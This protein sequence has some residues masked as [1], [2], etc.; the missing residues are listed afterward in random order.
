MARF[1]GPAEH[2]DRRRAVVDAIAAIDPEQAHGFAEARTAARL[3]GDPLDAID[4]AGT[5]PTEAL[6]SCL[7]LEP[8]EQIVADM[9]AIVRVIARG[10]PSSPESDAATERMLTLCSDR[11]GGGVPWVSILYQNF[12][13]TWSLLTTTLQACATRVPAVPAVPR[14]RRV[15]AVDIEW[16]GRT[17]PAGTDFLLEIGAAELPFGAGPHQC[18]GHVLARAIVAG[19]LAAIDATAYR[20]DPSGIVTDGDGRPTALPM[21]VG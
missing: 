6:A 3:T 9:L 13:A 18:P 17:I 21:S 10:A 15:A 7:A 4:I 19:I 5:V 1:S 16:L 20:V 12:D 14:T 2:A 11:P 8:L